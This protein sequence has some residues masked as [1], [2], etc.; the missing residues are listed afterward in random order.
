[1]KVVEHWN[2]RLRSEIPPHKI[3]RSS[4]RMTEADALARDPLAQQVEGSGIARLQP[5]TPEEIDWAVSKTCIASGP[6]NERLQQHM[7]AAEA[8]AW[9]AYMAA[10]GACKRA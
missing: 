7:R 4:W 9:E 5:E 1:M 6:Q 2:W 3:H 8:Q 10:G